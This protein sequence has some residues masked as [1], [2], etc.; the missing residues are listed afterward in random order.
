VVESKSEALCRLRSG[1]QDPNSRGEEETSSKFYRSKITQAARMKKS[2]L[3]LLE[4]A[5]EEVDRSKLYIPQTDQQHD[6]N[7]NK[8]KLND[9]TTFSQTV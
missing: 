1:I 5:A 2:T 9:E 3:V 4:S 8:L 6:T 7:R